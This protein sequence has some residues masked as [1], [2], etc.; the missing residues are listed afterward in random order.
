MNTNIEQKLYEILTSG[1]TT[2]EILSELMKIT[3]VAEYDEVKEIK[4]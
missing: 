2:G 4:Q 3:P 1:K